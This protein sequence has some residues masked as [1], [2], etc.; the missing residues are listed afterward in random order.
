ME[1]E[2]SEG[3]EVQAGE[4]GEAALGVAHQAAEA[5]LPGE[6]ALKHPVTLP[7]KTTDRPTASRVRS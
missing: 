6:G 7:T 5:H 1:F 4:G 2:A 3:D